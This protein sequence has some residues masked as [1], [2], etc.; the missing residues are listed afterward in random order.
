[1]DSSLAQDMLNAD[2]VKY[3]LERPRESRQISQQ[4]W[5]QN[6]GLGLPKLMMI[7]ARFKYFVSMPS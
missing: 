1:M 6:F 5:H 3:C 4:L 2:S 7:V